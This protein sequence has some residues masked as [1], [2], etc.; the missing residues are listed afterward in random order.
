L[1]K[2]LKSE[3][4]VS[5]LRIFEE[6]LTAITELQGR[7]HSYYV[8]NYWR[9]NDCSYRTLQVIAKYV[10]SS[11]FKKFLYLL[12]QH[13]HITT[14]PLTVIHQYIKALIS[15]APFLNDPVHKELTEVYYDMNAVDSKAPSLD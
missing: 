14:N 4:T 2:E 5:L 13:C 7:D 3:I 8:E 9:Y 12:Y 6:A 1:I 11:H 15:I 10:Y